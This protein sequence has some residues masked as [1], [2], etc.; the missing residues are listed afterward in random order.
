MSQWGARALARR[1]S[2][3]QRILAHFYPGARIERISSRTAFVAGAVSA[4]AAR[5][6]ADVGASQ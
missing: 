2:D 6:I 3:P 5:E 4:L 1:G